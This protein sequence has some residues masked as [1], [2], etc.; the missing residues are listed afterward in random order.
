MLDRR[1]LA[2]HAGVVQQRVEPAEFL[3][4]R[5]RELRTLR[6]RPFEIERHDRRPRLLGCDDGVVHRFELAHVTPVQQH[7][8]AVRG[9]RLRDSFADAVARAGDE[10]DSVSQRVGRGLV[11][12]WVRSGRSSCRS[13]GPHCTRSILQQTG[14]PM[15]DVERTGRSATRLGIVHAH[16]DDFVAVD[17]RLRAEHRGLAE[18]RDAALAMTQHC[19]LQ[20]TARAPMVSCP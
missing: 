7:G 15:Q 3:L 19:A 2:E 11:G 13:W 10:H 1:A 4:Q 12:A 8:G 9:C 6:A 20:Q 16:A 14:Q 5:G 18:H 17:G